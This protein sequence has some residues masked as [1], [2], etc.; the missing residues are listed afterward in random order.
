MFYYLSSC[1]MM[2]S[3]G[4]C[5]P[6]LLSSVD[7]LYEVRLKERHPA[8]KIV[9]VNLYSKLKARVLSPLSKGVISDKKRTH[10]RPPQITQFSCIFS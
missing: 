9:V 3:L 4:I 8:R 1:I 2:I 6:G 5:A 10:I 7:F